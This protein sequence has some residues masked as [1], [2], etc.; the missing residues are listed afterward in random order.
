MASPSFQTHLQFAHRESK[1]VRIEEFFS[2]HLGQRFASAWL[3]VEWGSSFRAR[4]AEIN[5]ER[6]SQITIKNDF[7]FD[8]KEGAE[9]S[10]YWAEPRSPHTDLG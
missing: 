2:A 7:F 4:V 3:H 5:A 6:D 10:F 1:K 8:E 9:I